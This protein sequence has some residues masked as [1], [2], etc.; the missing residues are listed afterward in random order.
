[1]VSLASSPSKT[2]TDPACQAA[3]P[4]ADRPQL[5]AASLLLG[6]HPSD[7]HQDP[8]FGL[9]YERVSMPKRSNFYFLKAHDPF[10]QG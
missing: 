10:C 3:A 2:S 8:G 5:T 1:M 9:F 4:D 7:Y 6:H